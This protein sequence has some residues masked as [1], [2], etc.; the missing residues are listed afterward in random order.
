[1][2][3]SGRYR[4]IAVT[5]TIRVNFRNV[6]QAAIQMAPRH[7]ATQTLLN[8]AEVPGAV[9]KGLAALRSYRI[10]HNHLLSN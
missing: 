7:T 9:R 3:P 5:H 2:L 1:M 6:S 10:E 8:H 4:C